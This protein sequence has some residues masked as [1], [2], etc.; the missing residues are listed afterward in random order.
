MADAAGIPMEGQ[1]FILQWGDNKIMGTVSRSL[2]LSAEEKDNTTMDTDPGWSSTK[3]GKKSF[4]LAVELQWQKG[5][6]FGGKELLAAFIAGTE[7]EMIYGGI[8]PTETFYKGKV[9]VS[10]ASLGTPGNGQNIS[11]SATLKGTGALTPEVVPG[12]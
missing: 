12:S 1:E 2:N 7:A 6:S 11:A 10:G 9:W 4:D 8:L 5:A 3:S